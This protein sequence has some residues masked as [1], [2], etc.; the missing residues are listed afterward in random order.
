LNSYNWYSGCPNYQMTEF[1]FI[2]FKSAGEGEVVWGW[3]YLINSLQIKTQTATQLHGQIPSNSV[4]QLYSFDS[5]YS[6]VVLEGERR[7]KRGSDITIFFPKHS[8]LFFYYHKMNLLYSF[9]ISKILV[10]I[11]NFFFDK[12]L[13]FNRKRLSHKLCYISGIFDNIFRWTFFRKEIF[14]WY[15]VGTGI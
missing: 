1:V 15:F 14:Q 9:I 12:P 3:L 6:L 4:L 13:K 5:G 7:Y 10:Y 8:F 2:I 11:F